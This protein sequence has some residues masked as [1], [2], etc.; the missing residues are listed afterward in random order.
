MLLPTDID[1]GNYNDSYVIFKYMGVD[2]ALLDMED[3]KERYIPLS[4]WVV[5]DWL[6]RERYG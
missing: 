2:E 4:E 6:W 3:L 5:N 1:N